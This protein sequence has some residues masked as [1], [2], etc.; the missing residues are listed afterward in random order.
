MNDSTKS[1]GP[2][3]TLKVKLAA[4]YGLLI[5]L[6]A[7]G[8]GSALNAMASVNERASAIVERHARMVNLAETIRTNELR[9]QRDVR[10]S[11]LMADP[12][13][14]D[15]IKARINASRRNLDE[16]NRTLTE[17][18][19]AEDVR[20][21]DELAAARGELRAANNRVVTFSREGNQDAAL[22]LVARIGSEQ[23]VR[24]RDKVDAAVARFQGQMEAAR[25]EATATYEGNWSRLAGILLA[26][27]VLAL[28]AGGYIIWNLNRSLRSALA[29]ADAVA[30]GDLTARAEV[31]SNDEVADLVHAL[32]RMTYRLRGV[33]EEVRTTVESVAAGSEEISATSGELS[34]GALRQ[35]SAT[36]EASA[37]MEEMTATIG[38]SSQNAN[39]TESIADA[40]A[41]T[42]AVSGDAV[43]KA[44]DAMEQ[45]AT[46]ILVVQEIARQTDLLALNAAVEA[47]RAGEYGRGFAVVASEVRKLAERSQAAATEIS[48]LS[49]DTV[50]AAQEAGEMLRHLVP[51]IGK[52]AELVQAIS[53]AGREQSVGAS[54]INSSIQDLDT[55][56]Q[57]TS[58]SASE[59][60]STAKELATRAAQ[61]QRGLAFFKATGR[62]TAGRRPGGPPP[63]VAPASGGTALEVMDDTSLDLVD[64][65]PHNDDF[66]LAPTG[67]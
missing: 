4:S 34:S 56:T 35:A 48:T 23:W 53:L 19:D 40:S 57:Q 44:V 32:R 6:L 3:V 10:E 2:R 31:R 20:V 25:A 1:T 52:T 21:L 30:E 61:L 8:V 64:L 49:A 15:A 66:D 67:T 26:S 16:A 37:A 27:V 9:V 11:L 29:M 63:Q 39:Q 51:E 7:F 33:V 45:I 62:S 41:A 54:Q 13:R 36:Q 55:I 17:M 12:A 46:K 42:A 18:A 47:A 38:Q 43:A 28:M 14:V 22:E 5:V 60:A 24:V 59:L 65:A 58:A 50:K